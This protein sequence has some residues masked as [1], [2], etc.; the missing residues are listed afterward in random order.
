MINGVVITDGRAIT[1]AG[2]ATGAPETPDVAVHRVETVMPGMWD[3]HAHFIGVTGPNLEDVLKLSP[4]TAAVRTIAD[5][6]RALMAG[7]TSIREVG[8]L[9][10]DLAV[11]IDEGAAVGPSIYGS[12]GVLSQT[13]GHADIHAFPLDFVMTHPFLAVCDGV[14]EVLK[15]VRSQLRRN[16]KVIKVCASGGVMS[17]IDHPI[18]QQFSD[19][20][21][22]AIVEEAARSERVVAAHCHGKPGIMAALRAGVKTIEHGSYLDGE[23]AEAMVEAG[24]VLVPTRSVIEQLLGMESA[25][26]AYA[27]RKAVAVADQHSLAIKTAITTGV[28][29]ATGTDFFVSPGLWGMNG[30]ELKH[31]VEHGMTPIQA[32]EAATANGPLTLGPQAPD[33]GVLTAGFDADVI[34]VDGNPL[35]DISVLV[36]PDHVSH[37]WRHGDLV[38][39]P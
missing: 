7:F 18:H 37:V 32:I 10:V 31:M 28:T 2:P 25:M 3:C 35:D 14:P 27:Y 17:E 1:Y 20:E 33:A 6:Q 8:G 5:A 16:A 29:I 30:L 9:G 38:K 23:A 22:R 34:A 4:A 21:L 39:S 12:G 24:A 19:E 11:A 13:G 15:T 36:G 26:P